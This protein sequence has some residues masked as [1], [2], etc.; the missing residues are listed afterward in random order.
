MVDPLQSI[1]KIGASGL[2]A[3]SVRMRV[4]AENIANASSTGSTPGA[5]PYTRKM[6]TFESEL[7]DVQSTTGV[8]VAGVETVRSAYR[9]E[10]MPGHPAADEKGYV[11]MPNV[12]VMV[13]VADMREA[14]RSYDANLQLIK[15]ARDMINS[16]IDMLRSS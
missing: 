10:H 9:L 12:D 8:K 3:Q 7:D 13:E 15:Q 5:D 1:L 14:N 11:K 16:A 2:E 4:L 6:V